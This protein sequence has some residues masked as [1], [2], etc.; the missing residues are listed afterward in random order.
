LIRNN[1]AEPSMFRRE[2]FYART[3]IVLL[4]VLPVSA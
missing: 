4:R 3:S 1:R 2:M